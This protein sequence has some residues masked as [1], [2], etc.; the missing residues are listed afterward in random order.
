MKGERKI[1]AKEML[2][3]I[4]HDPNENEWEYIIFYTDR[5][6][7]TLK[8]IIPYDITE[9]DMGFMSVYKEAE[10]HLIPIHRI[11]QFQKNGV[12]VWRRD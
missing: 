4:K 7:D 1:T 11:R 5:I 3:K 2:S 9:V 12:V 10:Y 6:T 8:E